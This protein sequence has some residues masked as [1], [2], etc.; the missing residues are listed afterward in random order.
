MTLYWLCCRVKGK[1]VA[2]SA[3]TRTM[4]ALWCFR[5]FIQQ[6]PDVKSRFNDAR[7]FFS[8]SDW[9]VFAVIQQMDALTAQEKTRFEEIRR[10]T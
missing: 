5:H 3:Q 9:A 4:R 10:N 2:S 7:S 6:S 1:G 8:C